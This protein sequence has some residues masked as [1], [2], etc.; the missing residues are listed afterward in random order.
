MVRGSIY[1][2]ETGNLYKSG[3]L[4]PK[5]LMLVYQHTIA[6]ELCSEVTN[7]LTEH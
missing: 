7:A 3:I 1:I 5:P 4:A 2:M 6:T